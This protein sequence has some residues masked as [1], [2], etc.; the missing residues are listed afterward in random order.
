MYE[1]TLEKLRG[2]MAEKGIKQIDLADKLDI[3]MS[4]MNSKMLGKTEFT[5]R[6]IK[7]IARVFNV[8]FI[9]TQTQK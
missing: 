3:S 8:E 5:L 4:A 2:L 1:F 7:E 9:I 6:E